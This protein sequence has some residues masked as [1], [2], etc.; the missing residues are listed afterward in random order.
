ML[1]IKQIKSGYPEHLRTFGK[2]L[3]R[4]YL[5]YKILEAIYDSSM[6]ETMTF[7]GGTCIHIVHGSP[8]FSEDL[9]FD[10]PGIMAEDFAGLSQSVKRALEL[11]GYSVELNITYHDAFRAYLRFPGLLYE[12]GISGHRDEKLLIQIDTEPQQFQYTP[13]K[14][15][16][17][18]FDVFSR[19]AIVP[20]DILLAQKIY[21]IFNRHRPMGRDFFDVVFLMG[22]TGVNFDYLT[23]KLSITN[24]LELKERLLARCLELDFASLSKDL[25]PFVYSQK[26]VS[27]VLLFQEFVQALP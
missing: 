17:N 5:Q 25:A 12:N 24:E 8:R 19:I 2:N 21:C 6:A 23:E 16:I 1:D 13:E 20:P 22:K 10:N 26:E 14:I 7:M 27:R 15:I 4:E 18:K 11:E 3:L 9:D